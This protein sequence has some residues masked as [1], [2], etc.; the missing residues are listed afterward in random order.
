MTYDYTSSSS[1]VVT[2]GL[3]FRY[4]CITT[5]CHCDATIIDE[6]EVWLGDVYDAIF[7]SWC[8][9]IR[10]KKCEIFIQVLMESIQILFKTLV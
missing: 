10:R 1:P 8:T 3:L 6:D 4:M 5:Y 7:D 2:G 9:F